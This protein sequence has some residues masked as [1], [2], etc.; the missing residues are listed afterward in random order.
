MPSILYRVVCKGEK[1][2][3]DVWM[4]GKEGEERQVALDAEIYYYERMGGVS[5][6]CRVVEKKRV[7]TVK[8]IVEEFEK[9]PQA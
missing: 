3:L 2:T 5:Y 9:M 6:G 1:G 8:E 4:P 7:P